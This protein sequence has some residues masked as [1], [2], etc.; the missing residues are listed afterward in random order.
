MIRRFQVARDVDSGTMSASQ[1]S[2]EPASARE[3]VTALGTTAAPALAR[4]EDSDHSRM[5][6]QSGGPASGRAGSSDP[7][8]APAAV[9]LVVLIAR[10][11]RGG[12]A[13]AQVPTRKS[14]PRLRASGG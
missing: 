9:E 10:F 3:G 7:R 14:R 6:F 5:A 4:G 1:S 13:G 8:N 11:G 12:G 2:V